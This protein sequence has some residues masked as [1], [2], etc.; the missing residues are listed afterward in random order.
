MAVHG[1]AIKLISHL[2]SAPLIMSKPPYN[3]LSADTEPHGREREN[4]E[5]EALTQHANNPVSLP[6]TV[7][8]AFW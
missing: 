8:D 4:R 7:T 5:R 1:K 3:K 2:I 6:N